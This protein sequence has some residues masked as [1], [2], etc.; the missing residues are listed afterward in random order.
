MAVLVQLAEHPSTVLSRR[1]LLATVWRDSVVNDETLTRAIFQLRQHLGDDVERPQFIETIRKGGYRLIAPITAVSGEAPTVKSGASRAGETAPSGTPVWRKRQALVVIALVAAVGIAA[2]SVIE[3]FTAG[4]DSLSALPT[5]IPLTSYP[6]YERYP[7]ISPDGSLIA[8]TMG[9]DAGGPANLY[10]KYQ[11]TE[12]ILQLTKS[13]AEVSFCAWSP[14]GSQLA[15]VRT[16]EQA[17]GVYII[18]AI[19]GAASRVLVPN[20]VARGISWSPDGTWLA[21]SDRSEEDGRESIQLLNLS[22]GGTKRLTAPSDNDSADRR[23]QFSPDGGSVAFVRIDPFGNEDIWLVPASGGEPKPVTR[24]QI[25]VRGHTWDPDGKH[26]VFSNLA[27]GIFRLWRVDVRTGRTEWLSLPGDGAMEPTVARDAGTLVFVA[28]RIEANIWRARL[29]ESG[30]LGQNYGSLIRSTHWETEAR[31]SPDGS[32]LAF[33]SSRSG[34]LEIWIS[35][36]GGFAPRRLTEFN[37]PL[38]GIPRWSPDGQRMAFSASPTGTAAVYVVDVAGGQPR[39]IIGDSANAVPSSWSRDGQWIYYT[40]HQ[41]QGWQI[42]RT[43]PDGSARARL[44]VSGGREAYEDAAGKWLYVARSDRPGL[45]RLEVGSAEV[46]SPVAGA[47]MPTGT[48]EPVLQD[49]PA[50]PGY[51]N[52]LILG[53]QL[54]AVVSNDGG[55]DVERVDLESH[56][57]HV[58]SALPGIASPTLGVSP[59][60]RYAVYPRIDQM[61]RDLRLFRG[62][63]WKHDGR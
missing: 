36:S 38:V 28:S 40:S 25:R 34:A 15:F 56:E 6:E 35:D 4:Q 10:V 53:N 14:D 23:P 17:A 55:Y 19:G 37:G 13:P 21:Y 57:R 12:S 5:A 29:D 1:D 24:G 7:A 20:S 2:V 41:E 3:A 9:D 16:D 18:P 27:S 47:T 32:Q 42:W 61:D 49:L 33:T 45:W 60:G 62:F 39:R 58:L 44:T 48:M 22:D 26:I 11:E 63:S 54:Y 52:W 59:D 31:Y 46:G 8:F 51:D 43:R 30:L 50:K